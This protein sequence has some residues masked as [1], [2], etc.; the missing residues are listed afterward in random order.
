MTGLIRKFK[1]IR[2]LLTAVGS[3]CR[4]WSWKMAEVEEKLEW[5]KVSR[6]K[7]WR[8]SSWDRENWPFQRK[9][10]QSLLID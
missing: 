10:Q 9:K 6:R 8:Q 2:L 1:K 4:M 3:C 7:T 5:G